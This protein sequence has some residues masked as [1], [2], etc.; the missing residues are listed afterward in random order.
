MELIFKA[1]TGYLASGVEAVAGL[2]IALAALQATVRAFLLIFKKP[3]GPFE[4]QVPQTERIHLCLGRWLAL[5]LEFELGA[6][7]LG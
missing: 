6:D 7:I 5:A 2:L 1:W 4:T 3:V